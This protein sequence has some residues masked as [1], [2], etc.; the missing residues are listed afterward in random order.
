MIIKG[1]CKYLIK[2]LKF[3]RKVFIESSSLEDLQSA[4]ARTTEN[5]EIKQ[6]KELENVVKDYN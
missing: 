4:H 5:F 1:T 3:E 2:L 6:S